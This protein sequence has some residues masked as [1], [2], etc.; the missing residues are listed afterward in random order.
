MIGFC[1]LKA[2]YSR[3]CSTLAGW[4]GQYYNTT[5]AKIVQQLSRN[6]K[7]KGNHWLLTP[8]LHKAPDCVWPRGCCTIPALPAESGCSAN[9]WVMH[10]ATAAS[11]LFLARQSSAL[12]S[13]PDK[14]QEAQLRGKVQT[15]PLDFLI[16]LISQGGP[17]LNDLKNNILIKSIF[18][19]LLPSGLI[20]KL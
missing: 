5:T 9:G 16:L 8:Y 12:L 11:L 17:C 18:A 14:H 3:A 20:L 7:K 15:I 13:N 19:Y 1:S 10:P 2:P 4:K 6:A